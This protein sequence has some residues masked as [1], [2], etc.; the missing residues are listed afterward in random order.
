[1]T[2]VAQ[3][4]HVAPNTRPQL[5][6]L[7]EK[8]IQ[9]E[10]HSSVK[11]E[12]TSVSHYIDD[13]AFGPAASLAHTHIHTKDNKEHTISSIPSRLP[14]FF[15]S[16][17]SSKCLIGN[18]ASQNCVS[19]FLCIL[20]F[21]TALGTDKH[22]LHP[23]VK[24]DC[25]SYLVKNDCL[26][27][28]LIFFSPGNVNQTSES[29]FSSPPFS[30]CFLFPSFSSS[31]YW[32]LLFSPVVICSITPFPPSF[33]P[34]HSRAHKALNVEPSPMCAYSPNSLAGAPCHHLACINI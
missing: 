5:A 22:A 2:S 9:A 21:G 19:S 30:A 33:C 18:Q 1:M 11:Q 24:N 26:S 12:Y 17:I 10:M 31:S 23:L 29:L 13:S 32:L 7:Q 25:S 3:T 28:V 6:A 20:S 15:V 27:Y 8:E 34:P 16:S 14:C 4:C